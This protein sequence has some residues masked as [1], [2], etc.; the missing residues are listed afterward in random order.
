[1]SED[2]AEA[3]DSIVDA[4]SA[5]PSNQIFQDTVGFNKAKTELQLTEAAKGT[6]GRLTDALFTPYITDLAKSISGNENSSLKDKTKALV[7][8]LTTV[9]GPDGKP[10]SPTEK[11]P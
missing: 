4:L 6:N 5:G 9:K 1:M 8:L 11:Q 10:L 3:R 7:T 2:L